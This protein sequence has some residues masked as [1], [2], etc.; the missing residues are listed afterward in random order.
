M[1]THDALTARAQ[2]TEYTDHTADQHKLHY[3]TYISC[4]LSIFFVNGIVG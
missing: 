3:C 4:R 1:T 2:H